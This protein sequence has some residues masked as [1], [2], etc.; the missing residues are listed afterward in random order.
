[1]RL[2]PDQEQII[3][4]LVD[5]QGLK[6]R[7]LRD[8]LIDHLCCVVES[9]LSKGQSFEQVL[10]NAVADLA[11]DGLI[12]I[13]HQTIFL[14][15]AKRIKLMK[16]IMYTTGFIGAVTLTAG[17]TLK[18]LHMPFASELFIVGFL[19]LFLIFIPLIAFDRYKVALSQTLSVRLKIISGAV[20]SGIVGLSGLFK[21]MHLQGADVLLMLGV[22]AFVLGFLPFY[23]FT[24]YR[25]SIS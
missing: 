9:E 17:V 13:Q 18:L 25:Q 10:E 4:N 2:T 15:N 12:A 19:T 22:V 23:F 20:A 3:E 14:L 1:M 7:T 8:D 16:Q 24:M 6:I 5:A 11:P 21:L